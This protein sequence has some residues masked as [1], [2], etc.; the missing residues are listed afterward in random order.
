MRNIYLII[1]AC[2]FL[3]GCSKDFTLRPPNGTKLQ[4]STWEL[5]IADTSRIFYK[6]N[7]IYVINSFDD[8]LLVKKDTVTYKSVDKEHY[9]QI[10]GSIDQ[11]VVNNR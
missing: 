3:F 4:S 8:S 1:S 6:E 7:N 2:L 10:F 9:R 11:I 5:P